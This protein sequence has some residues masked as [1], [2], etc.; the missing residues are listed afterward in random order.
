M[1]TCLFRLA[2]KIPD[3]VWDQV[4]EEA[5][6]LPYYHMVSD[7]IIPHV[8]PLYRFR[9]TA[10]FEADLDYFLRRRRAVSIGEFLEAVRA[11]GAPPNRSFLLTFDDGFREMHSVVMPILMKKGVPATFFLTSST[12]DNVEMVHHQ[13]IGLLLDRRQALGGRFP[14]PEAL[15][16]LALAGLSGGDVVAVLKSVPWKSRAALDQVAQACDL[17]FADYLRRRQPYVTSDDVRDLARNGMGIGAHSIDHP[18]YA[19]IPLEEQVR[20]TRE[21][22]GALTRQFALN[23][24]AFAFPHTDHGVSAEFFNR[25]FRGGILDVS[26]GTSG[27]AQDPIKLNFQRFT[28]EKTLLPAPAI[29]ARHRLRRLKLRASG[30]AMLSRS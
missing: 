19:E 8:S 14:E 25:V 20:Q 27:P 26:F 10:E 21:S 15:R 11:T 16:L 6:L 1:K 5:C 29:L 24:R 22:M 4:S 28:M 3:P 30:A 9:S 23:L 18:R 13:K 7:E 12:I 17:D 2:A